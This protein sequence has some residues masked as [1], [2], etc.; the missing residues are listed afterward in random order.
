[1]TKLEVGSKNGHASVS[2]TMPPTAESTEMQTRATGVI[3]IWRPVGIS[4]GGGL[5]EKHLGTGGNL[6]TQK[7][8]AMLL[9]DAAL[10]Q[11]PIVNCQGQPF[12]LAGETFPADANVIVI[13]FGEAEPRLLSFGL[14]ADAS[15]LLEGAAWLE[16]LTQD[17]VLAAQK[18]GGLSK[19]RPRLILPGM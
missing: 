5:Q 1:M 8:A 16:L 2:E 10:N 18:T 12:E 9:H 17:A 3:V 14:G 13:V 4:P 19:G 7:A 6:G 15:L 11:I